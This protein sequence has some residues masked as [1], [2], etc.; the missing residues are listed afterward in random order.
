MMH[1][2]E[3]IFGSKDRRLGGN[4]ILLCVTG[5]IAATET[6][7][8]ARELIRHGARVVPFMTDA[9]LRIICADAL[10]FACG[11]EPI[12]TLTGAVEHISAVSGERV[13]VIV[14]PA[15]ADV[16]GKIS[17]GL[18]DDAV[19]SLCLNALGSGVP[20]IIA[21][22]MGAPMMDNPFVKMNMERLR[23]QGVNVLPAVV[24]ENE[25]KL[26]DAN[27]ILV[28]ATRCFSPGLLKRRNVLVVGGAGEE[29]FDDVRFITSRSSG[30]TAV[31]IAT[32][33]YEQKANVMLWYGRMDVEIPS[34]IKS[35]AFRTL[36]DLSANISGRKF[37]IVIVP[38]SLPDFVPE[39]RSG[40]IPSTSEL[41]L[42]MR[43]APKFVD[44]VRDRCRVLVAFKAELG[45]DGKVIETARQR[46]KKGGFD[47]IVANSLD[48][49]AA[50]KT[51]AH[52][53]TADEVLTVSGTKRELAEALISRIAH[54]R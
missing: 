41:S 40:K 54:L 2:S 17:H 52:I 5:S 18:A 46:M 35:R 22:S 15:T 49:V 16:I 20:M 21:P 50:E 39:K 51:R 36:S 25:A 38:A 24:A 44:E 11:N 8:L 29:P 13:A 30:R 31:E 53:I 48:Q 14:A 27:T 9:A 1:P 42:R 3:R 33:A 37:D 6:V 12:T 7:K 26:L 43:R 4:T 19:T 10:Q 32:C 45:D 47:A 23:R 28:E 34:F